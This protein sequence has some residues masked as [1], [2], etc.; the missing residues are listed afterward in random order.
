MATHGLKRTYMGIVDGT[1]KLIRKTEL[2]VDG[3]YRSSKAI[4][5]YGT[6]EANIS[7]LQ[8]KGTPQYGDDA[9]QYTLKAVGSYPEVALTFLNMP[10]AI[11]NTLLG[12]VNDGKGGWNHTDEDI[13]VALIVETRGLVGG[14]SIYYAFQNGELI[15]GN[16]NIQ[17]DNTQI[18]ASDDVFTYT[19]MKPFSK[20]WDNGMKIFDGSDKNFTMDGMLAEVFGTTPVSGSTTPGSGSTSK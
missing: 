5:D 13:N 2:G 10:L 6:K 18:T 11:K 4:E 1:G 16:K 12:Y 3:I 7:N 9:P 14:T 8:G 17:T 15:E 20:E 19:S